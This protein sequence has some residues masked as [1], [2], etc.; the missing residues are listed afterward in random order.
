MCFSFFSCL[1]W[2]YWISE[3]LRYSSKAFLWC[4]W[5]DWELFCFAIFLQNSLWFLHSSMYGGY[6]I[7]LIHYLFVLVTYLESRNEMDKKDK[8]E[9]D[10]F[11]WFYSNLI[12]CDIINFQGEYAQNSGILWF[13]ACDEFIPCIFHVKWRMQIDKKTCSNDL[14]L[15]F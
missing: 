6:P 1:E 3:A 12:V 7:L 11:M 15:S 5:W 10:I 9:K 4:I 2:N 8:R 13:F 14:M